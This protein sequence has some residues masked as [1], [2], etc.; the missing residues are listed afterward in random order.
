MTAS[1]PTPL[2]VLDLTIESAPG[3][4]GFIIA[5]CHRRAADWLGVSAP[6]VAARI[7]EALIVDDPA[8]IVTGAVRAGFAVGLAFNGRF[9][10][11]RELAAAAAVH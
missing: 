2:P 9:R 8:A 11:L 5:P 3:E 1:D 6:A 4:R 7:G 10:M